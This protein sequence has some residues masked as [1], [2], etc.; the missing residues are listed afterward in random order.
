MKYDNKNAKYYQTIGADWGAIR[1]KNKWVG[2]WYLTSIDKTGWMRW[3]GPPSPA[4][5]K[6]IQRI[7]RDEHDARKWF[8]ER[9]RFERHPMYPNPFLEAKEE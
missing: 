9:N 6:A 4:I 7:K 8:P 3:Q 1:I 2:F 5:T